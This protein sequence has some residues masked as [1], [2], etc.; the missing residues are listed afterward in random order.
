M[1]SDNTRFVVSIK[2]KP[3]QHQIDM[4]E[5]DYF[6]CNRLYNNATRYVLRQVKQ[7]KRTRRYKN[8][9]EFLKKD[10]DKDFKKS[11][12][13]EIKNFMAEYKITKSDLEK[14]MKAGNR[15]AF[16]KS[17]KSQIF[18]TLAKELY[19]SVESSLF[20]G[21]EIKYR[22]FGTT[23]TL[24]SKSSNCTI[25][26]NKKDH[27]FKYNGKVFKL[28]PIREKDYY[29]QE[30]LEN[31]VAICKIVRK[32]I[33]NKY[34]YYLQTTLKG[35]PPK[36]VF[37]GKGIIGIDQGTSTIA[38]YKNDLIDFVELT[39][40]I[41]KYNKEIV[42]IQRR[43]ENKKRLNNP[44]C[45]N[46]DGTFKKGS[47]ITRSKSYQKEL[48]KL[49]D[50][51]R[52]KTVYVQDLHNKLAKF[53]ISNCD[54]IVKETLN[55]KA[56]QKRVKG[57]AVK[58]NKKTNIVNKKGEVKSIYKYKRKKRFGKSLNNHSP[59]YLNTQ[60][61]K[62]AMENDVNIVAVDMLEYRASQYNHL[63]GEYIKS[64][65]K[66][67]CKLI[68][69]DKVQR[70]LYS[71]FLLCNYKDEKTINRDKCFKEFDN[72]LKQQNELIKEVKDTTKNF[73]LI[74]FI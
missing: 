48:F 42:K 10:I 60:I 38:L 50:A 41:K 44:D 51:Y 53:I 56:L 40:D 43:M 54:T 65:L 2:I 28:K 9:V 39:P 29:L 36:K 1:S 73:G 70:D 72:F 27:N 67:R 68:G 61:L 37:R 26:F 49:K 69:D 58:Q 3:E 74:N 22:K 25:L 57:K 31:E 20:K 14:H 46:E 55:Y 6:K 12:Y 34:C 35:I 30:A 5:K 23:D 24:S 32:P 4:L 71:A 59:G 52:R 15:K 63:T 47:K 11:L 62:R 13:Q 16:C 45:Y 18:Q 7:I 64:E 21:T 19:K 66:D 33:K 17:I 8:I